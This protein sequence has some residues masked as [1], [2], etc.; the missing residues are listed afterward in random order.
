M[1]VVGFCLPDD[2]WYEET[3]ETTRTI[4]WRGIGI[5][6]LMDILRMMPS[7]TLTPPTVITELSPS[8]TTHPLL[9]TVADGVVDVGTFEVRSVW[10]EREREQE[11]AREKECERGRETT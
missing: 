5:W 8:N 10:R 7:L 3:T 9:Q 1:R 6:N 11:R 4:K 2:I